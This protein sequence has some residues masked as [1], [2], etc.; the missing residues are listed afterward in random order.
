MQAVAEQRK[1]A[2]INYV[3]VCIFLLQTVE[4]IDD[5]LAALTAGLRVGAADD[6]EMAVSLV[7]G[8]GDK[9][10]AHIRHDGLEVIIVLNS[11]TL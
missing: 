10:L 2:G 5:A 8:E 11:A 6:G 9:V 7:A 4:S 3:E 1:V